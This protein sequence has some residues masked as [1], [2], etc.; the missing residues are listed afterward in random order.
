MPLSDPPSKNKPTG[1]DKHNNEARE[2]AQKHTAG[3]VIH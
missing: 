1:P 3:E 2:P